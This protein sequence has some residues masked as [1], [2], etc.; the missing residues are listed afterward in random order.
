MAQR[1]LHK[2]RV[3]VTGA[4]GLLGTNFIKD[5]LHRH[6]VFAV[7]RPGTPHNVGEEGLDQIHWVE[8]D[9]SKPIEFSQMPNHVDAVVHLAQS[10]H[11]QEFPEQADDIFSVNVVSTQSLLDYARRAGAKWFFHAS[12]GS[13]YEPYTTGL[14]EEG[15]IAPESFYALSKHMAENLAQAYSQYMNVCVFRL[16]FLYGEGAISGLVKTLI[17]HTRDQEVITLEGSSGGLVFNPTCAG[18]V[19]TIMIRAMEEQWT[20][21]YNVASP[22]SIDIQS[23]VGEISTLVNKEPILEY[24]GV[25]TPLPITPNLEKIQKKLGD[26]KFVPIQKG[27]SIMISE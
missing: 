19:S 18:D 4:K 12:T 14:K 20:G 17:D 6:E 11:Y 1:P 2:M 22:Q 26:F 15:P 3:L 9:L 21:I 7:C 25:K 5:L 13:V 23:L 16:F 24:A 10:N 8:I 27:L